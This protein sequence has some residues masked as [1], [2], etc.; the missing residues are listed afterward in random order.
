MLGIFKKLFSKDSS[1]L[2]EAINNGAF[3]VDVRNP[4]E[5]AAGSVKGAVNIPLNQLGSQIS[6]FKGKKQ[7]VVFCQSGMRSSQAKNILLGNGIQHVVNG[8]SWRNV[9]QVVMK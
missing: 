5:F 4:S 8:G 7:I 1:E 9:Q 3:L 2:S 6:K